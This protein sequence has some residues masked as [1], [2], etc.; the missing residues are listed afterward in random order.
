MVYDCFGGSG[1]TAIA[2]INTN[3]KYII[4]EKDAFNIEIIKKRVNG[5]ITF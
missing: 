4:I 5:E 1:T 3:R 2:S